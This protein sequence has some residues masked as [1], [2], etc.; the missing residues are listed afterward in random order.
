MKILVTGGS[1]FIGSAFVR[2][3]MRDG[4]RLREARDNRE[5]IINLDKLTYAA[6][7]HT[8]DDE[9][10]YHGSWG[11]GWN[12]TALMKRKYTFI[13]GDI[14]D[15]RIVRRAMKGVS[16]VVHFAAESHV[17]RA[18]ADTA[19]FLRTNIIGTDILLREAVAQK[20][21]RFLLVSSDEVYGPIVAPG[22]ATEATPV[23]PLNPYA[24][25]KAAAEHLC[26]AYH[27]THGLPVIITRSSNNHGPYQHPEKFVPKT[28]LS[29][30]GR[31][32]VIVYGDGQQSR[33]WTH[34]DDNCRGILLALKYGE[35][36]T[37][38][39][40]GNEESLR[41]VDVV[42]RLKGAIER[43][44]GVPVPCR[45]EF[46]KDRPGHDERYAMDTGRIAR[47]GWGRQPDPHRLALALGGIESTVDFY[48]KG[49]DW[50]SYFA[51]RKGR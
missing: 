28:I 27:N 49:A 39:N 2:L 26:M 50:L 14:A 16:Y 20:V 47:L 24:A 29:L 11:D 32:P 4:S 22:R 7:P 5:E 48:R 17:D 43:Q 3:L 25:S 23:N 44:T 1:G 35:V 51:K 37:V 19:P 21:K 31:K 9:K 13:H 18:I 8:L 30:L 12:R 42:W 6:N 34:V 36:G 10:K 45:I 41:N 38:Y 40:I 46:V 33:Q 15:P